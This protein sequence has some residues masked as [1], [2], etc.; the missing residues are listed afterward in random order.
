MLL[1]VLRLLR[2]LLLWLLLLLLLWL[3]RL[4]V[5]RLLLWLLRLLG[6]TG[7]T[8]RRCC[9][10]RVRVALR[11]IRGLGVWCFRPAFDIIALTHRTTPSSCRIRK[12]RLDSCRMPLSQ[13]RPQLVWNVAS[14]DNSNSVPVS[15]SSAKRSSPHTRPWSFVEM[16]HPKVSVE[17]SHAD[18]NSHTVT[19]RLCSGQFRRAFQ[20]DKGSRFRAASP[21]AAPENI[22]WVSNGESC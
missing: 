10:V 1:L 2:L 4:L 8:R 20:I 15:A 5:L 6:Q 14:P 12:N 22:A 19:T 21:V 9:L 18:E 17:K 3:L 11:L 13:E 16:T 7:I